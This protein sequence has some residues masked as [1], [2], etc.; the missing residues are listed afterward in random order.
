[1]DGENNENPIKM[2]DLGG[3]PIFGNTHIRVYTS[4]PPNNKSN[5][6]PE[7]TNSLL[8]GWHVFTSFVFIGVYYTDHRVLQG[9]RPLRHGII[10]QVIS[11]LFLV[12]SPSRHKPCGPKFLPLK[13]ELA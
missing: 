9:N 3:T 2:D 8:L 5:T 12:S 1:M 7:K 10:P 6:V 4:Y 11:L 13:R